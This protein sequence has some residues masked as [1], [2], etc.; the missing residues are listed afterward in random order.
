V[1]YRQGPCGGAGGGGVRSPVWRTCWRWWSTCP[2]LHSVRATC[3]SAKAT[4]GRHLG[5]VVR[6][7]V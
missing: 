1:R 4:P 6:Q 7:C 5:A 3:W 2:R